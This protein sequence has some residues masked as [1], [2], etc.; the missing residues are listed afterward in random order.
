MTLPDAGDL[1][2]ADFPGVSG[3]KRRPAVVLSSSVYHANHRDIVL[4]LITTQISAA[5]GPTDHI[6][7]DWRA[8]NLRR[9]SA[10]RAFIVTVPPAT[11]SARVR[12][13]TD[14]DWAAISDCV[15]RVF[16]ELH[17]ANTP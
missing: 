13:L 1:V 16:S 11:I 17:P 2:V 10:F 8:A 6:L 14:R 5:S 7:Y 15:R 4:G 3:P 9:A 12:R